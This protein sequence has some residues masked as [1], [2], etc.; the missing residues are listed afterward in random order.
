MWMY[1]D[2]VIV[3]NICNFLTSNMLP[4]KIRYRTDYLKLCHMFQSAVPKWMF[5]FGSLVILD[6]AC[7]YLRL[8]SLYI[9][10]KIGKI[11]VK[12]KTSR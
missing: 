10:I 3:V 12:C 9:N 2:V 11:V 4:F 8:F 6:V 7:C 1:C 5:C